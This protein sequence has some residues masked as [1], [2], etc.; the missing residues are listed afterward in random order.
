M[1]ASKHTVGAS[2]N[3]GPSKQMGVSKHVGGFQT[4]RGH[5]NIKGAS[6]MWVVSK[7]MGASK[8]TVGASK[9]M[10]IQM[11]GDIWTPLSLTKHAF[12][13]LCMYGTSKHHQNIQR[14]IQTYVRGVQTDGVSKHTGGIP[15]CLPIPQSGFLPLVK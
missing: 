1:G 7:H 12:F 13:V 8:H 14:V 15:A 10:G 2:K 3:I 9:H 6:K 5:P 4:Y 11:Y